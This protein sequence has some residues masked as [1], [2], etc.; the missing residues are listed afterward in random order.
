M[1]GGGRTFALVGKNSARGAV[2]H[3]I[4][5]S[6]SSSPRSELKHTRY[7]VPLL[8]VSIAVLSDGSTVCCGHDA[9]NLNYFSHYLFVSTL[10]A[11]CRVI[12]LSADPC[13]LCL[14]NDEPTK[15]RPL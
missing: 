5:S 11:V 10:S 8:A 3:C 9:K 1:G 2:H 12:C 15:C 4:L 14:S 6:S 13:A 7:I